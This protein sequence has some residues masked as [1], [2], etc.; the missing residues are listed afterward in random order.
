M[1]KN[2]Q[3]HLMIETKELNELR[4]EAEEKKIAV[5]ERVRVKLRK[6]PQLDRIEGKLDRLLRNRK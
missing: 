5:A 2:S 4:V 3:L 1:R 6:Q